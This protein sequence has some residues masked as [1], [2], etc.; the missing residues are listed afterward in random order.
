MTNNCLVMFTCINKFVTHI[1]GPGCSEFADC[2]KI[3]QGVTCRCRPGFIGNG[4]TCVFLQNKIASKYRP[5]NVQRNHF[6]H[7]ITSAIPANRLTTLED[8]LRF[9]VRTKPRHFDGRNHRRKP[10]HNNLG[11]LQTPKTSNKKHQNKIWRPSKIKPLINT[12]KP[13]G[14]GLNV[15]SKFPDFRRD[16]IAENGNNLLGFPTLVI[17][18]RPHAKIATNNHQPPRNQVGKMRNRQKMNPK[19]FGR[20]SKYFNKNNKPLKED[21]NRFIGNRRHPKTLDKNRSIDTLPKNNAIR[22]Y[23]DSNSPLVKNKLGHKY[24]ACKRINNRMICKLKYGIHNNDKVASVPNPLNFNNILIKGQLIPLPQ[25]LKNFNS[26]EANK[27]KRKPVAPPNNSDKLLGKPINDIFNSKKQKNLNGSPRFHLPL[28]KGMK[29]HSPNNENRMLINPKQTELGSKRPN[30][31][32]TQYRKRPYS[33]HRRYK[34]PTRSDMK[35]VTEIIRSLS[36]ALNGS[37]NKKVTNNEW[38]LLPLYADRF[39]TTNVRENTFPASTVGWTSASIRFLDSISKKTGDGQYFYSSSTPTS[40]I[41]YT[42][43]LPTLHISEQ[44]PQFDV[45]RRVLPKGNINFPNRKGDSIIP[46]DNRRRK[47]LAGN[48]SMF[49]KRRYPTTYSTIN[50]LIV[51]PSANRLD[52]KPVLVNQNILLIKKFLNHPLKDRHQL[53]TGPKINSL[54]RK[55]KLYGLDCIKI[56]NVTSFTD[57]NRTLMP[58]KNIKFTFP[59]TVSSNS[60]SDQETTQATS[61]LYST[62]KIMTTGIETNS[63]KNGIIEDWKPHKPQTDPESKSKTPRKY[64]V[65]QP[66]SIGGEPGKN[67]VKHENCENASG[68]KQASSGLRYKIMKKIKESVAEIKG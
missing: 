6:S 63:V 53:N 16:P 68:E 59:F 46:N 65:V 12:H 52:T 21:R 62:E 11:G 24:V 51:E 64:A 40:D 19:I 41:R 43:T 66:S 48:N 58:R 44:Q 35:R 1:K 4:R 55:C 56:R 27:P 49:N 36:E 25:I 33:N 67:E 42:E 14:F 22:L 31:N 38:K 39:T 61:M 28:R 17:R 5:V 7:P 60:R 57:I 54:I 10:S 2:I 26:H 9:N 29:K 3:R 30:K 45:N 23:P 37:N 50:E 8:K 34:Q 13:R 15:P 32:N 20:P 47:P 18:N